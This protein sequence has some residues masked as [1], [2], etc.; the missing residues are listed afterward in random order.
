MTYYIAIGNNKKMIRFIIVFALFLAFALTVPLAFFDY[1]VLASRTNSIILFVG[2]IVGIPPVIIFGI[3]R[4]NGKEDVTISDSGID[5]KRFGH[6]EF[7]ELS[8]YHV[9][10]MSGF[11]SIHVTMK[12]GDEIVLSPSS[13]FKSDAIEIFSNFRAEFERVYEAS[14]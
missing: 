5:S 14:R 12:D 4:Y 3:R 13:N 6:L 9:H 8:L 10:Q 11:E 7:A 2:I 1:D